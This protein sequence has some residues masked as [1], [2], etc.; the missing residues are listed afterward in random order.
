M[1]DQGP[2]AK[3]EQTR[4]STRLQSG[5]HRGLLW[6]LFVSAPRERAAICLLW[7]ATLLGA[8]ACQKGKVATASLGINIDSSYMMRTEGI[9]MLVSDS[10]VTKYR[11]LSPMWLV[12]DR[13][14]KQEWFFPQGLRLEG[15]D[16]LN[17][18][19]VLILADTARYLP[20]QEEWQLWGDVRIHGP[21]GE[22]LYT[23]RLYW[24]KGE[25][26]L[27]SNDTTYFRTEGRELHGYRF[28]AKDDLS[29]YSI[30][31]NRGSVEYEEYE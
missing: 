15:Y 3:N 21:R 29:S 1:N 23:P 13:S 20:A 10:G 8:L 6:R 30:Y 18:S 19:E 2:R 17:P 4:I 14:D 11:L 26:R 16:T 31:N 24:L 5:S 12:Y 9:D 22:R 28:D 25:K 27:Y 7:L